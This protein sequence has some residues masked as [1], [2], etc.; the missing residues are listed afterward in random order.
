MSE[1][2]ELEALDQLV[3]SEGWKIFSSVISREWGSS[4]GGGAV[5][6]DQVTKAVQHTGP[7]A[8]EHLRQIVAAQREIQRAMRWPLERIAA[9]KKCDL[10]SGSPVLSRR[11]SL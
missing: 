2:V 5:F 3:N 1:N 6:V 9:L 10:K 4:E 8:T 7:E 11:G